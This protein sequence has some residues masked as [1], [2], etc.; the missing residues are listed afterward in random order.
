MYC[1][2]IRFIF[3][4]QIYPKFTTSQPLW[5]ERLILVTGRAAPGVSAILEENIRDIES[6]WNIF[7][8]HE[9]RIQSRCGIYNSS[10]SHS[11]FLVIDP[12]ISAIWKE[13]FNSLVTAIKLCPMLDV[14]MLDV[15]G[16]RLSEDSW[17]SALTARIEETSNP[18]HRTP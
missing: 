2:V 7:T 4:Q 3:P 6:L 5:N 12:N 14:P 8:K 17:I 18:S 10:S 16:A 9:Y 11:R 13:V 1:A 15:A